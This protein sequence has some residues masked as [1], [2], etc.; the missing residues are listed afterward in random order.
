M[1]VA[2]GAAGR[3]VEGL[4]SIGDA[5]CAYAEAEANITATAIKPSD[6]FCIS[7]FLLMHGSTPIR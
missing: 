6:V 4:P 7:C 2:G 1:V 3:T 5:D